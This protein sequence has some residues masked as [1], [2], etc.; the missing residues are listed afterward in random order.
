MI[1]RPPRSTLFPYTT[2]FRSPWGKPYSPQFSTENPLPGVTLHSLLAQTQVPVL[3]VFPQI[4]HCKETRAPQLPQSFNL[5]TCSRQGHRKRCSP[6]FP[7]SG[8]SAR[9]KPTLSASPPLLASPLPRPPQ[10]PSLRGGLSSLTKLP[11][12]GAGTTQK[13]PRSPAP[14]RRSEPRTGRRGPFLP[15]CAAMDPEAR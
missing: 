12:R 2:L 10:P 4:P 1:R 9:E 14:L 15:A 8:T 7:R 3:S 11:L 5:G 13:P 6:A